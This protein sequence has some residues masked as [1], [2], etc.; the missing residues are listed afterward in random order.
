[1]KVSGKHQLFI[2]PF[3]P[4]PLINLVLYAGGSLEHRAD[5]QKSN[6]KLSLTGTLNAS[7]EIKAGCDQLA[8]LSAGA[9]GTII[10]AS[11]FVKI[12][13]NGIEPGYEIKG[14]KIVAYV[15]ARVAKKDLCTHSITIHNGWGN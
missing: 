10:S 4:F 7:V 2:F 9:E 15:V 6:I 3:P 5:V 14:G 11:G 1:M 8:S 13:R 12:S